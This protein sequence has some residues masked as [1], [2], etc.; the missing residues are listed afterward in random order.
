MNPETAV[1]A[2]QRLRQSSRKVWA[3]AGASALVIHAVALRWWPPFAVDFGRLEASGPRMVFAVH[4]WSI[5]AC[6]TQCQ[7][8]TPDLPPTITNTAELNRLLMRSYASTLWRLQ[9]SSSATVEAVVTTRGSIR[10]ARAIESD[11]IVD[12]SLFTR[13]LQKAK[14]ANQ[15]QESRKYRVRV[16]VEPPVLQPR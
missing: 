13:M 1:T 12:P 7:W 10:H 6:E 3:I 5:K 4:E 14:V 9:E 15:G 16:A 11:D 8:V 2:N